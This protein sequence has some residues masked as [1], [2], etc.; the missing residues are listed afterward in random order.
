MYQ[1]R[2]EIHLSRKVKVNVSC[3]FCGFGQVVS[4]YTS[5][6]VTLNPQLRQ[7]V[8]DDSLN[9]F[10]CLDCGKSSFIGTNMIYHDMKKKFAVWFSPQASLRDKDRK[11]LARVSQSI[12]IGE[13]LLKAP[14]TRSWDDFKKAILDLEKKE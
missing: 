12:G 3:P 4:V 8:L 5:V 6:N 1:A 7:M 2:E 13:Y 10:V 14:T 9:R 11:A